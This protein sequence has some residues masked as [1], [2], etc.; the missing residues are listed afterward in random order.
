MKFMT[1][2]IKLS[3]P[4]TPLVPPK[5][6]Q[7]QVRLEI[8]KTLDGNLLISDHPYIDI[9]VSPEKNKIITFPKPDAE[10]ETYDY[11]REFM[12]YMFAGGIIEISAPQGGIRF[13]MIEAQYAP[14]S[15]VNTLQAVL[16][17]ISEFVEKAQGEDIV[18]DRYNQNIEDNF[19]DPPKDE[20]T[21][22][23]QVPPYQDTPA[24]QQ[25]SPLYSFAGYGYLY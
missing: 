12:D 20:T 1:I 10:K 16:Y 25:N 22:Y 8:R 13:G 17:R 2:K 24:G 23:G 11:Q 19:T 18:A 3:S 15:Q 6:P 7:A 5:P 9:V 21:A 4:D 14:T